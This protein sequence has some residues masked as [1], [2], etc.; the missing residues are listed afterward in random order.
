MWSGDRSVWHSRV[1]KVR[2]GQVSFTVPT[3]RTRGLS[4][5]VTPTWQLT[6]PI[7]TGYVTMAAFRY[8]RTVPGQQVSRETALSRKHGSMCFAGTDRS[9]LTMRLNVEK[10]RVQGNGGITDGAIAWFPTTRRAMLPMQ[11]AH[12]GILGAQDVVFCGQQ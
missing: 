6:E 2:N 1:R 5:W 3:P 12:Q 10:V 4:L 7:G 8:A 9:E 11:R